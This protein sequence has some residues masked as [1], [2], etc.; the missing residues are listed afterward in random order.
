MEACGEADGGVSLI[1]V[2]TSKASSA[3]RKLSEA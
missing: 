1:E 3:A 2:A